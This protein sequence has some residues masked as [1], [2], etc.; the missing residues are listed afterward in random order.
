MT[1]RKGWL[2]FV[3]HKIVM[4]GSTLREW[5]T[6]GL[7][8]KGWWM[9]AAFENLL[10]HRHWFLF[11]FP[12]DCWV[13]DRWLLVLFHESCSV[14]LFGRLL[15]WGEE[16]KMRPVIDRVDLEQ[17]PSSYDAYLCDNS[18]NRALASVRGIHWFPSCCRETQSAE[19]TFCLLGSIL[20]L[21]IISQ[22]KPFKVKAEHSKA[23]QAVSYNPSNLL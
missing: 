16:T 1:S 8:V 5:R 20:F 21:A 11:L 14:H 2:P 13:M 7:A 17:S 23:F 10:I 22:S 15:L 18:R 4:D 19:W 3:L 6:V 12:S 9:A